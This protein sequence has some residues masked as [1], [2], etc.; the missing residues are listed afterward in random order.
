MGLVH[1]LIKTAA[2]VLP[3]L[4]RLTINIDKSND[5]GSDKNRSGGNNSDGGNNS[6]GEKRGSGSRV[7][8]RPL[9][10]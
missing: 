6:G 10:A 5:S 8:A 4:S 9:H 3:M 2:F 7:C 1:R